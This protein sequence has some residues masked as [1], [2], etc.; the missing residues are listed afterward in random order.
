MRK[1]PLP[2]SNEICHWIL[3]IHWS[4]RHWSL[5]ICFVASLCRRRAVSTALSS[6][7]SSQAGPVQGTR[8]NKLAQKKRRGKPRRCPA[9][10]RVV[11]AA[12]EA[13]PKTASHQCVIQ[14]TG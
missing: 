8:L 14:R 11:S 2:P 6:I 12:S 5:V 4:L 1:F 7:V 13:Q 3:V 10:L 9:K